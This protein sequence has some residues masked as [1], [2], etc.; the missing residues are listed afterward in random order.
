MPSVKW[1]DKE[2]VEYRDIGTYSALKKEKDSAICD[3]MDKT[4]GH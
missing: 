1:M 3:N 2:Y 4:G